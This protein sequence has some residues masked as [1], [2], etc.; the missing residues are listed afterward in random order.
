[1]DTTIIETFSDIILQRDITD[2]VLR[3]ELHKYVDTLQFSDEPVETVA[4]CKTTFL[5]PDNA[6]EDVPLFKKYVH[7]ALNDWMV[8]NG[9]PPLMIGSPGFPKVG[10]KSWVNKAYR[11]DFQELHTHPN[12]HVCGIYY[13]QADGDE[14][15]VCFRRP[16][17]DEYMWCRIPERQDTASNTAQRSISPKTGRLLMWRSY[18]QH[19]QKPNDTDKERI[20]VVFNIHFDEFHN[21]P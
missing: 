5:E 3:Q 8:M 20:G 19:L 7:D 10:I 13:L 12:C 4:F 11:R 17:F 9:H 16:G 1:M 21:Q 2:L 15:D 18:L 6:I 14:G